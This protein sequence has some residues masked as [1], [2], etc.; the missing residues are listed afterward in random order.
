MDILS[1][2][3]KQVAESILENE[4]LVSGL[5][6]FSAEAL[7]NWGVAQGKKVAEATGDLDDERAEE[8]MYPQLK[9]LRRLLRAVRV[10]LQYEREV[11]AVERQKL[12]AK[13]EKRARDLYGAGLS[14]PAPEE[15]K[16]ESAAA[17]VGNLR[18]WLEALSGEKDEEQ[19]DK[20]KGNFFQRLFN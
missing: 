15:F 1:H 17:F 14:L 7:Q 10:W 5:D 12:W 20:E 3:I 9:A 16:A 2:R 13:V 8:M 4:G 19:Q 11:D 6:E 18:D